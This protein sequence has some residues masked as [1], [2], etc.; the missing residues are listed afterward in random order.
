MELEY[1]GKYS[2]A[3]YVVRIVA[4]GSADSIHHYPKFKLIRRQNECVLHLMCLVISFLK[5][6]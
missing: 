2:L 3:N 5:V 6:S 4:E 1:K